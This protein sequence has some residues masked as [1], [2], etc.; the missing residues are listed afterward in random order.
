MILM[1]FIIASMAILSRYD[2][3]EGAIF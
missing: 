3:G 2:N 1:V